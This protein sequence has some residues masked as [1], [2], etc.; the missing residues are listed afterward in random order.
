MGFE[1]SIPLPLGL[2]HLKNRNAG[3]LALS[4]APCRLAQ[5]LNSGMQSRH[6]LRYEE[7][8]WALRVPRNVVQSNVARLRAS[9]CLKSDAGVVKCGIGK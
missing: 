7:Y 2:K 6:F 3:A 5:E 4:V 9:R 1:L 8:E